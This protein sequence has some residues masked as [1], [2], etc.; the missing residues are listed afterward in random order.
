MELPLKEMWTKVPA[1]YY[2]NNSITTG[3]SNEEPAPEPQSGQSVSRSIRNVSVSL[4][5]EGQ[6]I[7]LVQNR[8]YR[9]PTEL[10]GDF[11]LMV[12]VDFH[13]NEL[14]I[15]WRILGDLE[16]ESGH[17]SSIG[18]LFR[19]KTAAKDEKRSLQNGHARKGSRGRSLS[20]GVY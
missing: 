4:D 8:R 3:V 17:R 20:K 13:S 10:Y 9:L 18:F 2:K 12:D 1:I 11:F 16:P 5:D 14:Q 6:L 7:T 19:T 15:I